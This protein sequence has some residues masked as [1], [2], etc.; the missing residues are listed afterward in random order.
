MN[1]ET[2]E[3]E[4]SYRQ[5]F[6]ANPH[7]MW[8]YDVQ[9]LAFLAVNDAT[10]AHYGYSREEFLAMTI[11][12]IRP[13]EELPRMLETVAR[14][15]SQPIGHPSVWRHRKKDGTLIDVEITSHGLDFQGRAARLVL[16]HDV[17]ARRQIEIALRES[18]E[19]FRS[20]TALS[21]DFYWETDRE[22]RLTVR[23][24]GTRT[25]TKSVFSAGPQL[26]KCRW[27]LPYV[28]PDEAGWREHRA[29]LDSHRA[30][31]DFQ[32]SRRADDGSVRHISI[33]GEPLFDASGAFKGY[34]GVGT[35]ITERVQSELALREGKARLQATMNATVDGI[36]TIDA[37]GRIQ[38][39]NRAAE[40]LFGYAMKEML[41]QNVSMLMPE[42]D[43]SKHDG[44]IA[45]YL[46]TGE[47]RVLGRG[48][49][50]RGRRKDGSEFD[51]DLAV[52]ELPAEAQAGRFIGSVRDVTERRRA[53]EATRQSEAR[54]RSL[55]DHMLE[56]FAYCRMLYEN[57]IARDFIY[58][59]VNPAFERLTGL[60]NVGGKK[61]SDVVPGIQESNPELFE[62]YGRVAAG[63]K[64]ERFE[65]YVPG[66]DIWFLISVYGTE[67]EH[68]IAVF[69][70]ITQRKHAE[71]ALRQNGE[72][73]KLA[74][75]ASQM[76]VWE[77]NAKT[78]T[79]FWSPE[80]HEIAGVEQLGAT[81]ESFT[82]LL[83]PNDVARV[84]AV[85][86][87]ALV[88]RTLYAAEF[89][90]I[91]GS[92]KII[93]LSVR[94]RADYD[95]TGKPARMVGVVQDITERKRA[96]QAQRQSAEEYRS[97]VDTT[98]DGFWIIGEEG[99]LLDVNDAYCRLTGYSRA[100]LLRM[101]IPDLE[102]FESA[103]DV[104]RH[105]AR[106]VTTGRDRFEAHHRCKD[107][108]VAE[109]EVSVT[110]LSASKRFFCFG[111]DIAGRKRAEA[112]I[113]ALNE[114]LERRVAA[115]T[116]ELERASRELE[117]FSYSVSHDLRAPLRSING[118]AHLLLDNEKGALTP[119]GSDYL[120][121]IMRNTTKM[122]QLID[123]ILAF[124][125]VTRAEL[126]KS[127]VDMESLARATLSELAGEYPKTPVR[128]GALPPAMGD[129]ALL[130]QVFANLI[131]NA[132]KYSAKKEM[133]LVEIEARSENGETVYCIRDNGAGFDMQY[134]DTLF[135]VFR[136]LHSAEDFAGTGVGLAI[137]KHIVERHGGRVWA[138]AAVDQGATFHFTLGQ[139]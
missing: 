72:R 102:A 71:H 66:L 126:T 113:R 38:S 119:T 14:M 122:Q 64:P 57:G 32:F 33:S 138:E 130:K 50:V 11:A 133:P 3:S 80:C 9:T 120:E 36:L 135:R 27:E 53:E 116:A 118:F 31:R 8:V 24:E 19:R 43:R 52:A 7:P 54:Y 4:Q 70:N 45:A 62:I 73:L 69:D 20:L 99:K 68:F 136:R 16:A 59:S 85:I 18:E 30:F 91:H 86:R 82:S 6:E 56:G 117:S 41:G 137:V 104:A 21:S 108:H 96:E 129:S 127:R 131:S 75:A 125:R 15:R 83:H 94:G 139:D 123:D 58:L 105:I 110:Y 22:H 29:V 12:N 81:L 98:A 89:R 42:P 48:R 121:R 112:E 60:K 97:L 76:G 124:S 40:A 84:M 87:Q 55:F 100:E 49:V 77:W 78:N 44:Y 23:S 51:L 37:Q 28:S 93:W 103:E 115:R 95:E 39:T 101:S 5:M 74:L 46:S 90:F 134:A 79:V 63:G 2:P 132:L 65:S 17:T 10:I 107:G 47:A 128:I 111:H 13:P 26:G 114:D 25:G 109:L 106:V 61:I 88:K 67:P 1:H 34:R 35:D 92:G